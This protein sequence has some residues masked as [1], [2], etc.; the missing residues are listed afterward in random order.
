MTA[1]G[2][3]KS[4]WITLTSTVTVDR[5]DAGNIPTEG[6]RGGASAGLRL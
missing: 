4:N 5:T 3:L 2:G 1:L 6:M